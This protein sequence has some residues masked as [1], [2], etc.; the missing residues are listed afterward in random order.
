MKTLLLI[1]TAILLIKLVVNITKY[2]QCK[3]YLN[4][5][6]NRLEHPK[7][8]MAEHKSRIIKLLK[9]ANV[10]DSCRG[11]VK[12][13]GFGMVQT[14]KISVFNEFS[15]SEEED[16]VHRMVSKFYEAIGVYKSRYLET[17]N[18]I[19]W[20]EFIINFPKKVLEYL[21]IA[22][23]SIIIRIIQVIYW[24]IGPIIGFFF[25]LY[26]LE[27]QTFVKRFLSEVLKI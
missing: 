10:S 18:P 14:T 21:G 17:F 4:K 23:E 13:L 6:L 1:F 26:R 27:I 20:I 8:D 3:N 2:F 16:L 19:Y 15:N 12:P 22:S 25:A 24:I 7:W 9:E 11:D 5:Y